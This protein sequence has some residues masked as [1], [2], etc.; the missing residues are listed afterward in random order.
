MA[1]RPNILLV[2]IDQ[3][4]ADAVRGALADAVPL[5][6]LRRF[7]AS[8]VTFENHF[9]VT[10]PCGP[11]RA[12]LLTGLYAMNHRVVR[13][14]APLADHHTNL[15]LEARK[16][17]YEP[18][19]F[20]YTDT[21][22][23]PADRDPSDPDLQTYEGVLPGFREVLEMRFDSPRAWPAHLAA[24][25]YDL[26]ADLKDYARPLA[27]SGAEPAIRDPAFYAAEHS[28]TAFLTDEVLKALHVRQDRPWFAHVTYIR[29]HPPLVAP[30][31]FNRMVDPA[32]IPG[33]V[34]NTPDHP[35][36]DAWFSAPSQLGLY[37]GFDGRCAAM[38]EQTERDLRAVYLGLLAEVDHHFGR[39]LDWLDSTDQAANTLVVLT[40]DHGEML[41]DH[42]QW[43][44]DSIFDPVFHVPLMIR[45]PRFETGG[46]RSVRAISESVDV[47]PT[48]LSA[49]GLK[50]PP[51]MDGRPLDPLLGG[52][53]PQDWRTAAF[54]E[55]DF[56][57]PRART[58]FEKAF[59]LTAHE[60]NAAVLREADWKLVHFNGGLPPLLFDLKADPEEARNV[61]GDV[62]CQ[63]ELI[64]L[65]SAMLDRRMNRGDR[66]LTGWS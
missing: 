58:R 65:Q 19:L 5:P 57:N 9:S 59:G 46:G 15:A 54:A 17:G 8:A 6:N 2:T 11:A 63:G 39:L 62:R 51:Q 21:Q 43:G 61:A 20:G 12:S 7:A 50:V 24:K 35:F 28:D 52:D 13:N 32:L 66:R 48:I 10:A 22:V 34:S 27:P 60:A 23:D 31:P 1:S 38:S 37:W 30:A 26:P 45:H 42:G 16:A 44:K 53:C 55:I 3:I 33:A 49:I 18:L 64:R 29:P 40:G 41:G 4:R 25:G 36:L 47:A 56:A 14:G